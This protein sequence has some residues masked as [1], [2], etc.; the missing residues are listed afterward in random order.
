[1]NESRFSQQT[2]IVTGGANGIGRAACREF[3]AAGAR[4]VP[5]SGPVALLDDGSP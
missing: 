4:V 1:M 5:P 2:A 3:G